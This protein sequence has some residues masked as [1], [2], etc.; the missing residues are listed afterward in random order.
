MRAKLNPFDIGRDVNKLVEEV[1]SHMAGLDGAK[2]E[3]F[4]DVTVECR[5]GIP[6]AA[7]RAVDENCKS[8]RVGEHGFWG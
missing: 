2:M 3:A 6:P 4:L 7:A 5:K 1:L 8:L